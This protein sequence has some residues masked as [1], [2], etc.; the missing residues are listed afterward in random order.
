MKS[1]YEIQAETF[2]S[3]TDTKM[4]ITF[5]KNDFHFAGDKEKRDIYV[6]TLTRGARSFSFNFGNS[7]NN[8]GFYYTKGRQKI[9]ISREYLNYPN[10]AVIIKRKDY[11]FLNNG[12]SDTIHKP[13]APTPYNILA[14]L[15][16]Y[17]PGTFECFCS[18]FGY[19]K[20]S[21][22]AEKTYKAVVNEYKSLCILFP[23]SEMEKLALIQ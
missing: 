14:S 9:T 5:L 17:D 21:K 19:D 22:T 18:E 4:E 8:S 13:I 23:D 11:D 1:E 2:L 7:L 6:V 20:D 3:E 12:G 15:T 16:K 10:L